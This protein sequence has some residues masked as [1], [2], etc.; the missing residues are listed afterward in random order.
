[1]KPTILVWV[2]MLAAGFAFAASESTTTG[3][4]QTASIHVRLQ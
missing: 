1:M 4:S 2:A 3:T